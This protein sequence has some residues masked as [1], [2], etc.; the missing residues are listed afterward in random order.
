MNEKKI[1]Q[2]ILQ[3]MTPGLIL[4]FL[5]L[6]GLALMGDLRQVGQAM[7]TFDWRVYPAVLGLTLFNYTLRFVKWHYYLHVIGI[8][9]ITWVESL[10]MFVGGFP[11]A[12]TPGKVGEVLKGVWI[13]QRSGLPVARG[14][15][16]V[17]AER[18]SDGLAVMALSVLGVVAYPQYWPA[19]LVIL[20][21]LLA[22]LVLAQ[23]RPAAMWAL[24]VGE[25]LPLVKRFIGAVREFYEG[26]YML[27]Q[28]APTA[29][30]VG[31]GTISW[32]GEG[33]GFYFILTGLGLEPSWQLLSLAVFILAFSTVVGAVSAL[34]GGMGA[35]EVSIA[36]M[37]T[38]LGG[39]E[40][41]QATTATVLIR[42]AT[43]WFGI[44]LGLGV[45]AVS[46]QLIGLRSAYDPSAQD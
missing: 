13:N 44:L 34:P 8:H 3:R 42:L 30:A 33:V 10:R 41:A 39:L 18:I 21:G 5:V 24:G 1:S 16:V 20:V 28:P 25:R 12:I 26:S 27:F 11:L 19:F 22:V 31:L 15:S 6:L 7:R 45:W 43:L 32:L 40:P 9:H 23:V 17:A 2:P 35:A 37:L 38:L 46:P 29:A 4:G 14:V 36:G